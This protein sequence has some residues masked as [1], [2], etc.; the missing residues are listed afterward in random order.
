LPKLDATSWFAVFAPINT[1]A[2]IVNQLT[3]EIAKVMSTPAFKQKAV[4][5]GAEAVY[6][7]PKQ[8]DEFIKAENGRWTSVVKAA[9][10]EAD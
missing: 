3:T 8:L 1:P 7:N 5:M 9:K 10:I 4:E 2:P 6:M